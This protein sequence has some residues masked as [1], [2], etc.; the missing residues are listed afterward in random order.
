MFAALAGN[1]EHQRPKFYVPFETALEQIRRR[2]T[3][4]E[5]LEKKYPEY[6][7]ALDAAVRE[8]GVPPG[9]AR[10]LPVRHRLG[11]STAIIDETSGKPLSYAD[12]DPY[13]YD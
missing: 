3:K 2:A 5:E 7:P 10:W 8:A 13:G 6:K 9:N 12:V 4:V 11:F 1:E